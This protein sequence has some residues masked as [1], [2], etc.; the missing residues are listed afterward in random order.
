MTTVCYL[1]YIAQLDESSVVRVSNTVANITSN[2][3][4]IDSAAVSIASNIIEDITQNAIDNTEVRSSLP[5]ILYIRT[6]L[7]TFADTTCI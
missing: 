4:R 6:S 1:L 5:V 7:C 2:V 3:S